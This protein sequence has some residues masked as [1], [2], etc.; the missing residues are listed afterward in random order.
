MIVIDASSLVKYLLKEE[1]WNKVGPYLRE[2]TVSVDYLVIEAA[3]AIWK[4]YII[5]KQITQSRALKAFQDLT[6]IK[7]GVL[8]LEQFTKYIDVAFDIAN[9][10][11]I[12]VYDSVYIAQANKKRSALLTSDKN[13]RDAA[14]SIG[15][16]AKYI[17]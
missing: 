13:Q 10:E 12:S 17:P 9:K 1:N 11:Q 4:E 6:N 5:R 16:E 15:I 3:N 7:N 14:T 8:T 2:S